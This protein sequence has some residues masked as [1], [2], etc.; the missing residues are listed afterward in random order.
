MHRTLIVDDDMIV[1]MYLKDAIH[2]EDFGFTIAGAARDGEEALELVKQTDPDLILTDIGM[3]RMNGIE[4][5]QQLRKDKYDGVIHVLSC[6]D[7][8]ELVKSALQYGADDYFLK[9]YLS[10][11][12]IED[13]L[14]KW[15]E[16]I[17]AR[18]RESGRRQTINQLV[19]RGIDVIRRELLERILRG[20]MTDEMYAQYSKQ[21][22]LHGAY[23]RLT[24]VMLQ[25]SQADREQ[26]NELLMLC[27]QRLE[28]EAA[29]ILLLHENTMVLLVDLGDMVS[30]AQGMDKVNRS[31]LLIERIA[32]QYLNIKLSMAFSAVCEGNDAIAKALR[33]AN[34]TLQNRFYGSGHWRYGQDKKMAQSLPKEANLFQAQLLEQLENGN[35]EQMIR[36]Y[37]KAM[38]AMCEKRVCAGVLLSWLRQCDHIAGIHRTENQ[39]SKMQQF[40]DYHSC[41]EEYI[42]HWR[43][44]RVRAVPEHLSTPMR[45]A[46]TFL[47]QHFCE[48]IGLLDAAKQADLSTAY[49]STI[50]KQ[51]MGMG[52]SEYLLSLRLERVCTRLRTTAQTIKQISVQAGFADY[53]YF[54]RV[55]KKNIGV[56]PAAYR[57]NIE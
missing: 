48:P 47:Q 40:S 31:T 27:E 54:C 28:N 45:F 30:L 35:E 10:D 18:H 12:T 41:A 38:Q 42:T 36:S 52:F 43:A 14:K 23:R 25:P 7:D 4:L 16:Q 44:N 34:E 46:V 15:D 39:Y 55:F 6:H 19:R 1:R 24:V 11:T 56:G 3:P 33:Q 2:W 57:K 21:A 51:E 50:F 20:E 29:D 22:E 26:M 5:I 9:N 49:F 53:P 37:Q 8:F 32:C 17:Q 13:R